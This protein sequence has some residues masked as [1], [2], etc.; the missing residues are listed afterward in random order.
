MGGCAATM[1]Y[2]LLVFS[3]VIQVVIS[4]MAGAIDSVQSIQHFIF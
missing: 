1:P 2:R 4:F 3:L